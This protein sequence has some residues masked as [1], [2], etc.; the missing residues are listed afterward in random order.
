[1]KR[2]LVLGAP[3]FQIP[4]IEKAKELGCY[5]GVVDIDPSAKAVPYADVYY[6]GSLRDNEALIRIAKEFEPD[7]IVIGACDTSVVSAA[8]VCNALGLPG[9]TVETAISATNKLEML[10]AF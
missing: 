1:M 8:H 4:V 10:H 9:H 6:R 2:V 3:V 7:G 5:V